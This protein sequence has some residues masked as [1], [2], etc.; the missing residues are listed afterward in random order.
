L[1]ININAIRSSGA[2]IML[3]GAVVAAQGCTASKKPA[4][5]SDASRGGSAGSRSG[6]AGS[7][8]AAADGSV[9]DPGGRGGAG[10]AGT[11][12]IVD[13]G[14]DT[15]VLVDSGDSEPLST[16]ARGST[17][18]IDLGYNYVGAAFFDDD[19]ILRAKAAPECVGYERSETKPPS[20]AGS[21]TVT[22]DAVGTATGLPGPVTIDAGYE[23]TNYYVYQ[24]PVDQY[25]YAGDALALN[26]ARVEVITGVA[27]ESIQVQVQATG[28]A[29]SFPPT[30]VTTLRTPTFDEVT[31]TQPIEPAGGADLI[32]PSTAPFIVNWDVPDP[33]RVPRIVMWMELFGQ[34]RTGDIYCSWESSQGQGVVPAALLT[35]MRQLIGGAAPLT[36]Y[37]SVFTGDG[38]EVAQGTSSYVILATAGFTTLP[39]L[40]LQI[41]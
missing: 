11:S 23:A 18:R 7:P 2:A 25:F 16:L 5:E 40:F 19:A 24:A 36:G 28:R 41:Q 1:N 31:V 13:A 37:L 3:G 30:H 20:N 6:D 4:L 35:H 22:S 26:D 17:G 29:P 32:V 15:S 38:K 8:R 27:P 12:E 21:L 33:A 39:G 9:V 10:G 34:G 14:S